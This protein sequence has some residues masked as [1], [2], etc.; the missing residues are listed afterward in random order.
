MIKPVV[1]LYDEHAEWF[2]EIRAKSRFPESKYMTI[3]TSHL[4]AGASILDLGC[5]SGQPIA[6]ALVRGGFPVTGVDASSQLLEIARRT[7][8]GP[9]WIMSDMRSLD[10]GRSFDAVI[11]WNSFFH[12]SPDEQRVVI[13]IIAA[14]TN[15][16]GVIMFTSGLELGEAIGDLN[17]SKLYH[18]SLSTAE[19]RKRLEEAG[20]EILLHSVKDP[21]CGELTVWLCR[22][23][24]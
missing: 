11:A 6:E 17:G 13:P 18:G 10:L 5:G 15:L 1:E 19:Y 9:E 16:G 24:R 22:R 8:S 2:A 12:L 14:H 7:V 4:S 3:L 20:F 21:E 23:V